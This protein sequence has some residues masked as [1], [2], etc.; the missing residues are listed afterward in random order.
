VFRYTLRS[1]D[2]CALG[3]ERPERSRRAQPPAHRAEIRARL[4]E[5]AAVSS[6]Q[7]GSV[8]ADEGGSV[9]VDGRSPYRIQKGG[10]STYPLVLPIPLNQTQPGIEASAS[11]AARV[12]LF[13]ALEQV[14]EE[15]GIRKKGPNSEK[16]LVIHKKP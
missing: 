14:E 13:W 5:L 8:D 1:G 10:C 11:T 15:M 2:E 6:D 9:E 3:R 12:L 4:R 16:D 7:S